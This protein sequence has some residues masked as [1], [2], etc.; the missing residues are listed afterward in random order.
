MRA[1]NRLRG[2]HIGQGHRSGYVPSPVQPVRQPAG[3]PGQG[4]PVSPAVRASYQA[5][6]HQAGLPVAGSAQIRR[7][8]SAKRRRD[9]LFLL[10]VVVLATLVMAVATRSHALIGVQV[11]ADLALGAYVALLIRLRNLAAERE[12]KLSY[13]S[14]SRVGPAARRRYAEADLAYADLS[15]RRAAN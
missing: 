12:V 15:L 2:P 8:Q 10:T 9:V 3:R 13:L 4:R 7:R 11:L 14:Q 5:G 1:A 6:L